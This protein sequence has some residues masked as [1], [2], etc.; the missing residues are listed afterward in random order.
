VLAL[1]AARWL[2]VAMLGGLWEDR[3]VLMWA[4]G[5]EDRTLRM[6]A[7]LGELLEWT[8]C[9]AAWVAGWVRV[10]VWARGE[11]VPLPLLLLSFSPFSF[12]F[13]IFAQ[14]HTCTSCVFIIMILII[15]Y[16]LPPLFSEERKF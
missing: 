7:D 5:G 13:Y 15:F 4:R 12:S 3:R 8:R 2:D 1:S 11:G 14:F 9:V 10:G 16:F 6:V